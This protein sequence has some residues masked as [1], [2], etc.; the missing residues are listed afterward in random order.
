MSPKDSPCGDKLPGSTFGGDWGGGG[1]G[2]NRG[3]FEEGLSGQIMGLLL[4]Y[5]LSFDVALQK[6]GS[7]QLVE[8]NPFGALSGCGACLFN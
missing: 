2:E 5:G 6:D 4:K 7:V 8:I 3:I 1:V